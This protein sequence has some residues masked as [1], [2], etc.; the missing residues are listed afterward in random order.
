MFPCRLTSCI[1]ATIAIGAL[2]WW[3]RPSGRLTVRLARS[4][5]MSVTF[6]LR[7]DTDRA[8]RVWTAPGGPVFATQFGELISPPHS[9]L[10]LSA[11]IRDREAHSAT[12]YLTPWT[13]GEA[14]EK[15]KRYSILPP[16]LRNWFCEKYNPIRPEYKHEITI[17]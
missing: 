11:S 12:V 9:N 5:P 10:E 14:E 7:N 3:E 1:L 2:I 15:I 4:D 17:P 16:P 6:S 8:F 13:R